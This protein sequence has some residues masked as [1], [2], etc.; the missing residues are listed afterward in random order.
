MSTR[1]EITDT[2]LAAAAE[3]FRVQGYASTSM[4]EIAAAVGLSRPALYYHF[5]NKEEL[6]GSLVEEVTVRTQREA[7]RIVASAAGSNHAETL[8]S[9]A[10]AQ[11]LWILRHPQ[12][13]AVVQR[14]E[15]S[16]PEHLR[17]IQDA[18]KRDLLD[19]FRKLIAAGTAVGQ[20]RQVEPTIVALCIFGMCNSTIQWFRPGGRL[21]E[22]QV[23]DVIADMATAMVARVAA[24]DDGA[25]PQAWLRMVQ[26]D[27]AHLGRSLS[28]MV[29][30]PTQQRTDTSVE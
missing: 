29:G 27:L 21:S 4:Q 26:D 30:P 18:A 20:F 5:K 23:A 19:S 6:L 11:A 3:L 16:L 15:S 28:A 7:A 12:H 17:A 1:S 9:M 14:D 2:I 10:R 24:P 13:F 8:R 22:E 25:D